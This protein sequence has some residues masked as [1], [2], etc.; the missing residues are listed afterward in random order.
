MFICHDTIERRR[1]RERPPADKNGTEAPRE[2]S[3]KRDLY[4]RDRNCN[5]RNGCRC[6]KKKGTLPVRSGGLI[7][8]LLIVV[9]R[10]GDRNSRG[11]RSR[12]RMRLI[13]GTRD[14]K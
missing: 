12:A 11:G 3:P 6:K 14:A 2:G 4:D 1:G 10:F 8:D 5:C 13:A 9:R 7:G